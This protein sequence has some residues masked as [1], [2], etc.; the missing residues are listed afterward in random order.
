[1]KRVFLDTSYA[2]VLFLNLTHFSVKVIIKFCKCCIHSLRFQIYEAASNND[3]D[4]LRMFHLAGASLLEPNQEGRSALHAAAFHNL[5]D[6]VNFFV[7]RLSQEEILQLLRKKD[8]MG[9]TPWQVAAQRDSEE[10]ARMLQPDY[11]TASRGKSWWLLISVF[12]SG[13][14]DLVLSSDISI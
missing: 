6:V 12:S 8:G 3:V 9:M 14:R 1:M 13:I 11:I 5:P 10:I 7:E 2:E 4:L